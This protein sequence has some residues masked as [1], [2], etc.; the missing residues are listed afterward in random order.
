MEKHPIEALLE[1][2]ARKMISD[3]FRLLYGSI[4]ADIPQCILDVLK[5]LDEQTHPS[6]DTDEKINTRN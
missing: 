1:N 6:H 5:T 4:E 3:E 2:R